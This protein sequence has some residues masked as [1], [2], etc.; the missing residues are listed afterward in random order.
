MQE[1]KESILPMEP[2]DAFDMQSTSAMLS[3]WLALTFAQCKSLSRLFRFCNRRPSVAQKKEER[4]K[5]E[6]KQNERRRKHQSKSPVSRIDDPLS[7]G[8]NE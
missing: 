5:K 8:N 2:R 1:K 3:S 4:G 6:R 7:T